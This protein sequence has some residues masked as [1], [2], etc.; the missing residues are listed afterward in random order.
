RAVLSD[1][2]G[3]LLD[4]D[5]HHTV[6][7]Y[8]LDAAGKRRGLGPE[9]AGMALA[10]AGMSHH[11]RAI[12]GDAQTDFMVAGIDKGTGLRV[13]AADLGATGQGS[14]GKPLALAVGDT[15]S[16]LPMFD[17]AALAFAPASADARVRNSGMKVLKRPY[18]AGLALAASKLLGHLP[19]GC[20]ICRVAHPSDDARLLLAILGAREAG[21]RGL[22]RR[23]LPLIIK[24]WRI[25][26]GEHEH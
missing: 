18:Q 21:M 19:G 11:V 17:L 14:G 26:V 5:Y 4:V 20:P 6:R 24:I 1:L 13:L 10:S 8:R 9:V 15:F 7:A 16:D 23:A 2:P 25:E 22:V 12:A 3:V